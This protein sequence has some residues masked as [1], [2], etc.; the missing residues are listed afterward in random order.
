[1]LQYPN[2]KD[3][4]FSSGKILSIKDNKIIHHSVSTDSGSSGSPIIE[5]CKDNYIIGLNFDEKKK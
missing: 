3:I 2:G 4:S 5:R 1:M